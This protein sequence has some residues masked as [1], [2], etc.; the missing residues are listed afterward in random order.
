MKT[1][2]KLNVKDTSIRLYAEIANKNELELILVT[3]AGLIYGTFSP[4]IEK[5]NCDDK[6]RKDYNAQLVAKSLVNEINNK[7]NDY[8]FS[9]TSSI[10]LTD[11]TIYTNGSIKHIDCLTVFVNDVI[12]V[13]VRQPQAGPVFE[14]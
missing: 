1:C 8:L 3:S 14:F 9:E 10:I 6:E 5:F 12:A 7:D 13:T 2:N 11:V 4:K